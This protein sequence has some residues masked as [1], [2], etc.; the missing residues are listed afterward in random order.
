[1][2][3]KLSIINTALLRTGNNIVNFEGDGSDEWNVGSDAY[4]T[5]VANLMT[6]HE[7]RFG[8][9][10]ASLTRVGDSPDPRF[11][12]AFSKPIGCLH[13]ESVWIASGA[14]VYEI[15]D[16]QICCNAA[17][18]GV[19][20]VAKFV[21]VPPNNQWP[22]LF[23]ETLRQ[24]VMSHIL[25]GLNEDSDAADRVYRQTELTLQKARNRSDTEVP[26][27]TMVVSRMARARRIRR[28]GY[29]VPLIRSTLDP[30]R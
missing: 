23:I 17:G 18:Y 8:T 22:P 5:E 13:L 2:Y 21:P 12:D 27:R 29:G 15:I 16:N 6:E 11:S 25:R 7:W 3:D 1:M 30:L 24:R 14:I 10:T 28:G 19:N 20:P 26:A 4:E 9:K